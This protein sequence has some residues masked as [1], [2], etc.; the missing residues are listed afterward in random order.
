[1]C[2]YDIALQSRHIPAC[3][4]VQ[5]H[6]VCT[7]IKVLYKSVCT[8]IKACAFL[9]FSP[10]TY[11]L[12]F[13]QGTVH[14]CLHHNQLR[15]LFAPQSRHIP[16]YST[17]EAHI[18]TVFKTRPCSLRYLTSCTLRQSVP[19]QQTSGHIAD[20]EGFKPCCISLPIS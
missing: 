6:T 7:S 19:L 10:G 14:I 5:A 9:Q 2:R 11:R 13:N 4:S 8:A 1:M 18:C 16:D 15:Y 3:T 12:H 20:S 17:M